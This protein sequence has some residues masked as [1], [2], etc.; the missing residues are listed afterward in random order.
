MNLAELEAQVTRLEDIHEIENLER[1]YGFYFDSRKM[2]EVVDLFSENAES[3]EIESHGVY[4]GKAGVIKMY[5]E[6]AGT[7]TL[8]LVNCII[9]NCTSANFAHISNAPTINRS[10]TLVRDST[11]SAY[12]GAGNLDSTDPWLVVLADN[13][14]ALP[15]H[16]L[17]LGSPCVDAGTSTGAPATDARGTAR[18]KGAAYDMGAFEANRPRR[19]QSGRPC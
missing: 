10:Y 3:V 12:A 1:I 18:P 14:G 11:M 15:T 6:N 7:F 19:T 8:N 4:Y 13:G 16:A 17:A 5:L 9:S 2:K